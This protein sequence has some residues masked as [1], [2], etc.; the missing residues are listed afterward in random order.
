MANLTFKNKDVF[1]INHTFFFFV[2]N[3]GFIF[4]KL[5]SRICFQLHYM[6]ENERITFIIIF[7]LIKFT[8][9]FITF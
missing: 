4:F 9:G 1:Q 6:T 5:K 7:I 2:K 8:F 3:T